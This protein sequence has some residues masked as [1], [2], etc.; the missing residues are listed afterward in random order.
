MTT[1]EGKRRGGIM[2]GL[3]TAI[4]KAHQRKDYARR[5][6]LCSL[7]DDLQLER[8]RREARTR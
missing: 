6:V 3:R 2:G 5:N 4:K 1:N 8:F 7:Y